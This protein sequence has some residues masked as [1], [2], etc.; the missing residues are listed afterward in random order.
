[1]RRLDFLDPVAIVM[2][3][4]VGNDYSIEGRRYRVVDPAD[5]PAD[6]QI[7]VIARSRGIT[8]ATYNVRDFGGIGCLNR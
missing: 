3:D 2:I 4:F 6:W 8:V 5:V 7:A 1:M